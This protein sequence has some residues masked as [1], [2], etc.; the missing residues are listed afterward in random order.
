[1]ALDPDL[2][3]ILITQSFETGKWMRS[4]GVRFQLGLGRQAF[5]VD[6]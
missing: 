1:M 5:Q 2:T 6:G 4:K 3:E